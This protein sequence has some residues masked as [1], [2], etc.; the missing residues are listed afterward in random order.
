[1]GPGIEMWDL[2]NPSAPA[3]LIL[4]RIPTRILNMRA[5]SFSAD[6]KRLT[7]GNLDGAVV[8]WRLGLDAA[9]YLC[10]HVW[11]NLS[12]NEWSQYVG[13]DIPYERT[14][15]ALPP[16]VGAPGANPR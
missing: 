4:G 8:V 14:C 6:G 12:M 10:K 2:R 3:V 16:G 13:D 1:M 9:D 11:R 7:A 15:P 5:V